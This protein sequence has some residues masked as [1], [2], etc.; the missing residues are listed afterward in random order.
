[1]PYAPKAN[2]LA[3]TTELSDGVSLHFMAKTAA[4]LSHRN[5]VFIAADDES[6]AAYSKFMKEAYPLRSTPRLEE[7]AWWLYAPEIQGLYDKV[8]RVRYDRFSAQSLTYSLGYM[9]S[10]GE[11][12]DLALLTHGVP[13]NIITSV[14]NPIFTWSDL[15]AL[16]GQFRNL[17]LVFM[18]GCF[19]SSL[20]KDWQQAGAKAVL[21]FP[22]LNRNFFYLAFS[23]SI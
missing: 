4:N 22:D 21:S 16:Q 18:Q 2:V 10:L 1:V 5:L 12:Y 19:G 14:G 20:A 23:L 13:N 8:I 11:P 3:K 6:E 17:R 9:E 15:D 7:V